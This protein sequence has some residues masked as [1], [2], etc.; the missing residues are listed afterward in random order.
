MTRYLNYNGT[1][2]KAD[3]LIISADNRSFRYGDGLFE[4]MKLTHGRIQLAAYHFE[5]LFEGIRLL[6]FKKPDHL[7]VENLNVQVLELSRKNQHKEARVRLT[8]FRGNGGFM[9]LKIIIPII[10]FKLQPFSLVF[11]P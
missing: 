9:T 6:E 5:R 10:L 7:T 2:C 3:R 11:I 8:V 4:T 1:I